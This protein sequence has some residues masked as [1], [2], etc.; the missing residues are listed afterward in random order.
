MK[1]E[2]ADGTLRMLTWRSRISRLLWLIALKSGSLWIFAYLSL[3][4][5]YLRNA[6]SSSSFCSSVQ[7]LMGLRFGCCAESSG[8]ITCRGETMKTKVSRKT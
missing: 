7:G 2:D 6:T 5:L 8:Y 1:N 3:S 4:F